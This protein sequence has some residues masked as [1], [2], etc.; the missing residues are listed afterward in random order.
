MRN[1][2][3]IAAAFVMLGMTPALTGVSLTKTG[4]MTP[5]LEMPYHGGGGG[6]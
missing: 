1:I 2:L 3:F 6:P 5:P 4:P